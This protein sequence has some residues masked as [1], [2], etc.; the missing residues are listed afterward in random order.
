MIVGGVGVVVGDVV[1]VV[2]VVV[3]AVSTVQLVSPILIHDPSTVR[4]ITHTVY[5]PSANPVNVTEA[6]SEDPRLQ[7]TTWLDSQPEECLTHAVY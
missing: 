5:S 7:S 6:D 2:V 1:S 4:I 3:S